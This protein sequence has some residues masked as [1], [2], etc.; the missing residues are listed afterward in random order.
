MNWKMTRLSKNN[1][2]HSVG[3]PALTVDGNWCTFISDMPEMVPYY[4]TK[5]KEIVGTPKNLEGWNNQYWRKWKCFNADEEG[6][7]V[8]C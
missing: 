1:S 6:G 4:V 5:K 2:E 8:F 7:L 3:H